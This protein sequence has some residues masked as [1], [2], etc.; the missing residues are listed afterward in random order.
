MPDPPQKVF[1]QAQIKYRLRDAIFRPS[2]DLILEAANLLVQVGEAR[3]SAYSDHETC[4]HPNGIASDISAAIQVVYDVDQP[5]GI[6]VKDR[7]GVGIVAH[8]G[9][10]AGDTDEVLDPHCGRS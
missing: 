3:I 1:Q 7:R 4:A 10:I 2:L 6:D 5:D 8:L 9:G